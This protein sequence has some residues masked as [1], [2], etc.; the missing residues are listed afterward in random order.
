MAERRESVRLD[1]TG[2]FTT[3][4]ARA[5]VAVAALRGDV[6]A[7]QRV[8]A[9]SRSPLVRIAR[10]ADTLAKSADR[11]DSS[12][13]QLTGRLRLFADAAAILG[14]G[15]A[16]IGA[17]AVPAITGLASQLGFAAIGMGTLVA[18]SQGVGDAFKAVVEADLEPTAENLDAAAD[19]MARIAPEAQ[20]FVTALNDARPMFAQWR[21]TAAGELF[22]GVTEA[23]GDLEQVS[24]LIESIM[25]RVA[26][27]AG[28]SAAGF[29]DWL[30]GSGG[31]EFLTFVRDEAPQAL[32]EL[33]Q[34]LGALGRG[35]A[36]LWMGF[37]PLN[38]DF[39]GWLLSAAEGFERW[40]DGLSQTEGFADFI[41]YVRTNGPIVADAMQSLAN[42]VLQ[43]VEAA[44][45]LGGPVLQTLGKFA[46]VIAG[47]AN[48]D[49]GTP[50]M[51]GVAALALYNRALA[52]TAATSAR[53]Q[54]GLFAAASGGGSKGGSGGPFAP[55]ISG[56]TN[57]TTAQ[58]RASTAAGQL[59]RRQQELRAG[60]ANLGK[61]AGLVAGL[62]IAATGAAD[63]MGL[64][65]TASL[66]LMGT[67]AGPWGAAVGGAAGLLMDLR[68]V[69]NGAS[70]AFD[71]F[72]A[73]M[74]AG[75]LRGA[76]AN[77]QRVTEGMAKSEAT[78]RGLAAVPGGALL[79]KVFGF[80]GAAKD[81]N[82][83]RNATEQ[84]D[85]AQT[86]AAREQRYAQMFREQAAAMRASRSAAR[87]T[88]REFVNLGDSL[89][90]GKTS[91]RGWI[92]DMNQQADALRNFRRNAETAANR[93][94][95]QGLIEALH[96]AGPA[97]ALRMRQLAN[98][99]DAEIARANRAWARGR[100]EM[101]R[102]VDF[103]V[104]P[105][106]IDVNTDP[107]QAAI[108][109]LEARL[110]EIRDE[111]VFV[112]VRH[113][114]TYS[115]RGRGPVGGVALGGEV[116]G[117][118]AIRRAWAGEMVPKTGLP[119]ADRHPYLLA[120]GEH[121]VTNKNGEADQNRAALEAANR[122]AKLAIMGYANGGEVRS[123][124]PSRSSAVHVSAYAPSLA[125]LTLRAEVDG[126]G[127]VMFRVAEEVAGDHRAHDANRS[128]TVYSGVGSD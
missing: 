10:D 2:N 46:D 114:T 79:N 52:V 69:A 36:D 42:A 28:D 33:S 63:G 95:R 29:G 83:L 19:A 31:R 57:V 45:P 123:A 73:S 17:L 60:M 112:N 117:G 56:L 9:G 34:T 92:R 71:A 90:D 107:A 94:L 103:K 4:V 18:A 41:D 38:Q 26:D 13:N 5:A 37:T 49:L 74:E 115:S 127:E 51:A 109:A 78:F 86:I 120:D 54:G 53:L 30:A 66:A 119:Y 96:E 48:S 105:K 76:E 68:T 97:G 88:A 40:A 12:I 72:N 118:R 113:T 20:A 104:P 126:L 100:A 122:G 22:P 14:P 44:A 102:Y 125:G 77:L 98:A 1:L 99:T 16:P 64:S 24:G 50:I 35:L 59:T 106:V 6:D 101:R 47:I 43:I 23:L 84:L 27:A 108:N 61:S 80:D 62:G 81:A 87:A 111:D 3:E 70:D 93:G 58:E 25:G 7:L 110:R 121:V 124:A 91:L 65:N 15:L 21:D 67:L 85:R 39:S 128:R 82:R 55:L 8:S 89:D 11:T 75:D 116:Q 32:R